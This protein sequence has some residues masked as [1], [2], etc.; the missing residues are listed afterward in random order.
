MERTATD[1]L[2]QSSS[3]GEPIYPK[4]CLCCMLGAPKVRAGKTICCCSSSLDA[5]ASGVLQHRIGTDKDLRT[6]RCLFCYSSTRLTQQHTPC[7]ISP[8]PPNTTANASK[9]VGP[10]GSQHLR[11]RCHHTLG[12]HGV[13]VIWQLLDKPTITHKPD[14]LQS[15]TATAVSF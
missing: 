9:E 5:V 15:P 14:A 3:N 1:P 7:R 2:T 8:L 12:E 13:E 6:Q 10:G 4:L 11:M